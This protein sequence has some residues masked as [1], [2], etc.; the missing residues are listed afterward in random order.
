MSLQDLRDIGES[1]NLFTDKINVDKLDL[2]DTMRCLVDLD[3]SAGEA[4]YDSAR[5]IMTEV[6]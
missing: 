3:N 1:G 5:N 2:G 6:N 4:F